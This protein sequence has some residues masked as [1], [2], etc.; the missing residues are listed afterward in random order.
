MIKRLKVFV[1]NFNEYIPINDIYTY[2]N[3]KYTNKQ[4]IHF[5][6]KSRIW[7]NSYFKEV[8]F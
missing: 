1:F 7:Y 3:K 6:K 4:F 2:E 8:M 5:L